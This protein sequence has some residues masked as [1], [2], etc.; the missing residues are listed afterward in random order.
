MGLYMKR[1]LVISYQFSL[2]FNSH[3]GCGYFIIQVTVLAQ[4]EQRCQACS[5]LDSHW[6][7]VL[8]LWLGSLA[9]VAPAEGDMLDLNKMVKQVTR[10]PPSSSNRSLRLLLGGGQGQ[11]RDATDW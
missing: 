10:R 6:I 8:S 1:S 11:P 2:C 9:G 5:P 4:A 7:H 3:S